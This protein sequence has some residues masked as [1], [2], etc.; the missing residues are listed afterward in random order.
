[1][2]TTPNISTYTTV[3]GTEPNPDEQHEARTIKRDRQEGSYMMSEIGD[4]VFVQWSSCTRC[5][6]QVE[7]CSCPEGPQEPAYMQRWRIN[8]FTDSFKGR[9]VEPALPE[10]LRNRDRRVNAV[11]RYL[12][13]LGFTI[14]GPET[15]SEI[16]D[17]KD[18]DYASDEPT[19]YDEPL[20]PADEPVRDD[21]VS[22]K[23]DAGMGNAL[24]TLRARA[25]GED[26]DPGF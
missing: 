19:V 21:V 7:H 25:Q 20:K 13:D 17:F 23:V 1:M 15:R 18:E 10:V 6:N 24:E 8:R 11:I 14:E 9:G 2:T 26:I 4:G 16:P 3:D 5:K 22:E 12:L